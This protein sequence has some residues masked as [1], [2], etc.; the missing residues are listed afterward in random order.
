MNPFPSASAIR[1]VLFIM[2]DQLRQD[3]LGCYG[4][5]RMRTRNIDALAARSVRFDHAY[6]T[7]AVCG[8]SRMSFYTGRYVSSHGATAN[9]VPLSLAEPTLGD[10][11]ATAGRRL[12]LVGKTHILPDREG[13]ARLA[14]PA[15][16]LRE[17]LTAG[18]FHELTR[19]DG[20]HAETDSH[21]ADWLRAKGYRSAD[22]WTDFV[23]SGT[24]PDGQ[25]VSGWSMRNAGCPARVVCSAAPRNWKPR[26]RYSPPTGRR[27][28]NPAI[29]CG[30]KCPIP[31]ARSTRA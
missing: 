14:I 20:H 15:G 5:P 23:I 21:Y 10:Y 11:L 16:E 26:T 28:T 27:T 31:C 2:C 25:I 4:H 13:Y 8:P 3:H 17:R 1:N 24:A 9:L 22:P 7:A 30:G 29:S 6:A 12:S 18:H 19:H